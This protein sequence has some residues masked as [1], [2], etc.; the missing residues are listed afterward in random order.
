MLGITLHHAD[1]T[2]RTGATGGRRDGNN[3]GLSRHPAEARIF[4]K[5]ER[6]D[7]NYFRF[8]P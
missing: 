6:D 5:E 4:T 8:I 7:S 2:V 3:Y 1:E